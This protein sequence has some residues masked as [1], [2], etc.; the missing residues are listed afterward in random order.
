MFQLVID[1]KPA[2]LRVIC[3]SM[4][5]VAMPLPRSL[6]PSRPFLAPI[7]PPNPALNQC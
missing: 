4:N 6:I 5:H 2:I 3:E 1:P 7:E